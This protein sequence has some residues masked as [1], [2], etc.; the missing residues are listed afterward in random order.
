[1]AVAERS[2]EGGGKAEL[3][4]DTRQKVRPVKVEELGEDG[5]LQKCGSFM[6]AQ[7]R[8]APAA[9]DETG[10]L[11]GCVCVFP[12]SECVCLET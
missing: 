8:K 6:F 4:G 11:C 12:A 3:E 9:I 2:M 7:R 10:N 1:M 5:S